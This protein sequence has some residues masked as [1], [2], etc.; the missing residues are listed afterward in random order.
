MA[1]FK[2]I[3]DIFCYHTTI[4]AVNPENGEVE[5]YD[6]PIVYGHDFDHAQKICNE[7]GL[8]FAVVDGKIES[9]LSMQHL[10]PFEYLA[11]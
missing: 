11:Y 5:R 10:T 4:K 3:K 7:N 1:K 2:T 6:G 8:S 9:P